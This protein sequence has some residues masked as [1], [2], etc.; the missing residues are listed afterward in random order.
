MK[1]A[2]LGAAALLT[3][4]AGTAHAGPA[5]DALSKCLVDK[6]SAAD[7]TLLVQ[8]AYAGMSQSPAVRAMSNVS[9][10]QRDALSR[11]AAHLV[12]RLLTGDCRGETVAALKGGG[13]GAI[14]ASTGALAARAMGELV[15]DPKVAA[16]FAHTLQFMDMKKLAL[17]MVESGSMR[18]PKLK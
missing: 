17:L 15:A 1:R 18:L 14:K 3:I 7:R 13:V 11:D 9:D 8:W 12:E 5:S 16:A 6:T 4:T 10:A 2:I